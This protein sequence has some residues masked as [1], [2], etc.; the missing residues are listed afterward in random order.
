M[1][2]SCITCD[3]SGDFPRFTLLAR[4]HAEYRTNLLVPVECSED[5]GC[6]EKVYVIKN[7]I[8]APSVIVP[9]NSVLLSQSRTYFLTLNANRGKFRIRAIQ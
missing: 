1:K 6:V 3:V 9:D 7:P 4:R 8:T 2:D 5:F